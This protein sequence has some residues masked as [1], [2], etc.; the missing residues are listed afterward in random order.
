MQRDRV[1]PGDKELSGIRRRNRLHNE[2]KRDN[3]QAQDDQEPL[4]PV[5]GFDIHVTS[6]P[7][8]KWLVDKSRRAP[9]SAADLLE[10]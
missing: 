4:C 9:H 10:H 3:N 2:L 7:A 8:T 5:R 1:R 6:L